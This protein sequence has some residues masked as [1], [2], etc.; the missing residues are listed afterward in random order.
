MWLVRSKTF[1][2]KLNFFF[3]E[4]VKNVQKFFRKIS[5]TRKIAS[6]RVLLTWFRIVQLF[7][8]QTLERRTFFLTRRSTDRKGRGKRSERF[9]C[10][11]EVNSKENLKESGADSRPFANC[12]SRQSFRKF[13][14]VSKVNAH[15]AIQPA[16]QRFPKRRTSRRVHSESGR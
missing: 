1:L 12:E 14:E 4:L 16:R 8:S 9:F 5:E 6:W 11:I 15:H 13:F 10:E 2:T 3:C 7:G